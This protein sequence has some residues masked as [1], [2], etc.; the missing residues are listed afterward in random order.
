MLFGAF[1]VYAGMKLK[2]WDW[3]DFKIRKKPKIYHLTKI[4][5]AD[6]LFNNS[7][8]VGEKV[9]HVIERQILLRILIDYY[10]IHLHGFRKPKSLDVLK[11]V[12]S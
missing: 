11:E 6:Q 4:F 7:R 8:N 3:N 1:F 12:F 5:S 2:T 10:S 9:F